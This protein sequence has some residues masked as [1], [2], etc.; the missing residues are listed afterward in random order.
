VVNS[1]KY[2]SAVE[3]RLFFI[4]T[5]HQRALTAAIKLIY[6]EN[7]KLANDWDK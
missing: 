4:P 6:F 1:K 5:S 7:T 2:V 3:F